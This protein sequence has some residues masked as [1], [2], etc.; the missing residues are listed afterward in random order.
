MTDGAAWPPDVAPHLAG[1]SAGALLLSRCLACDRRSVPSCLICPSCGGRDVDWVSAA[2]G[3]VVWARVEFHKA[4]LPDLPVP[5]TV[6]LVA[7]DDGGAVYGIVADGTYEECDI[8]SAVQFDPDRSRSGRP[9][10]VLGDS[11]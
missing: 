4:Y 1:L 7:L 5:Y 2:G 6:V 8:G 10:F 9:T 3:G 11:A